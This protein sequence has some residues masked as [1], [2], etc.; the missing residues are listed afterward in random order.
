MTRR[1]ILWLSF[2][3]ALIGIAV[4]A[5]FTL[6]Q[7]DTDFHVIG[8]KTRGVRA[9]LAMLERTID[10]G[11]FHDCNTIEDAL[12]RLDAKLRGAERDEPIENRL[13]WRRPIV[14]IDHPALGAQKNPFGPVHFAA[15][16]QPMTV[17]EFLRQTFA[18]AQAGEVHFI[19]RGYAIEATT[20]KRAEEVRTEYLENLSAFERMKMMWKELTGPVEE[21]IPE[22]LIEMEVT[23]LNAES[24]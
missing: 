7:R 22:L 6:A 2:A 11:D 15:D 14:R 4:A 9:H 3:L 17:K 19:V 5:W 21:D 20:R 1:R 13:G 12:W 23:L 16:S 10:S 18:Q 8:P 24:K